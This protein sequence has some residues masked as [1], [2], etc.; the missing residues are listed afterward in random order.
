M[1]ALAS[2]LEFPGYG[3]QGGY[4]GRA[5]Q[6]LRVEEIKLGGQGSWSLQDPVPDRRELQCWGAPIATAQAHEE[7]AWGW[8][9]N[10]PKASPH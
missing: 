4:S 8:E 7:S 1:I 10:H 9:K 6:S 5:Q 2:W 3:V